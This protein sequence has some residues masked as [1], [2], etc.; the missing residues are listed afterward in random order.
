MRAFI[1]APKDQR[2]P[3]ISEL[4]N[5]IV[6]AYRQRTPDT[7]AG[8][9]E[10]MTPFLRLWARVTNLEGV[11]WAKG[12]S[13]KDQSWITHEFLVRQKTP[14][15]YEPQVFDNAY[16]MHRGKRY[17]IDS[18]WDYDTTGRFLGLMCYV[19]NREDGPLEQPTGLAIDTDGDD[20]S[21]VDFG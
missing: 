12:A 19:E 14:T 11:T 16:V 1:R 4:R 9:T 6:V 2:L 20:I 7:D 5:P 17:K 15:P 8:F 18:L 21:L 3:Q 13:D 10:T